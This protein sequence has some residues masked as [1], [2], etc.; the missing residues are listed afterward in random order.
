LRNLFYRP[1][2]LFNN[3][4]SFKVGRSLQSDKLINFYPLVTG[5]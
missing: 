3:L 1:K 2:I 5:W 4:L